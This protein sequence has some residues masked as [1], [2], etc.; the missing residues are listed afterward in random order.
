MVVEAVVEAFVLGNRLVVELR[1]FSRNQVTSRVLAGLIDA[2]FDVKIWRL[3]YGRAI[4][5]TIIEIL[6]FVAEKTANVAVK[7]LRKLLNVDCS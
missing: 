6:A 4:L 3:D 5:A 1:H 2:Y 7:V